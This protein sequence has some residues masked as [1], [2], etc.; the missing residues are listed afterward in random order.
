MLAFSGVFVAVVLSARNI[1]SRALL[2]IPA[3]VGGNFHSQCVRI[4][5]LILIGDAGFPDVAI[6]FSL[7]GRLI[8]SR[9]CLRLDPGE[10]A[11]RLAESHRK[12]L[13]RTARD[14]YNPTADVLD[15]AAG[16]SRG[17]YLRARSRATS[18]SSIRCACWPGRAAIVVYRQR[19]AALDWSCELARAR[20]WAGWFLSSGWPPPSPVPGERHPAKLVSMPP[21]FI[22]VWIASRVAA[23]WFWCRSPERTRLPRL[24]H[25]RLM[26]CGFRTVP[27]RRSTGRRSSPRR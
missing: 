5:A 24:H 22:A 21:A 8:A 20:R 19:L 9:W 14:P 4:A 27:L 25:D 26:K 6:R 12:P 3:G 1:F 16:H 17:R 23:R 2:L 11:Q 10:P 18:S 13:R 7:A 15:A